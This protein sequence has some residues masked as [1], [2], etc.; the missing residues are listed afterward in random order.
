ML[1]PLLDYVSTKARVKLSGGW[2]KQHKTTF[3]Y[4]KI[5]SI[6]IVYDVERS[7]NISSYPTLEN[8]LFGAAK[9]TNNVA[10]DL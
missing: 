4:K 9:L 2:L 1:N 6:Y 5:V 8:C 10:V 7:V 3:H